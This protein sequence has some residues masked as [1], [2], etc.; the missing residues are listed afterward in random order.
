MLFSVSPLSIRNRGSLRKLLSVVFFLL[1]IFVPPFSFAQSQ[2]LSRHAEPQ[3]IYTG[4]LSAKAFVDTRDVFDAAMSPDGTKIVLVRSQWESEATRTWDTISIVNANDPNNP[5]ILIKRDDLMVN[6]VAWAR[7]DRLIASVVGVSYQRRSY[8]LFNQIISIDANTGVEKV[9]YSTPIRYFQTN[10]QPPH[11]V[12]YGKEDQ[13]EIFVSIQNGNSN[14]LTKI[15]IYTGAKQ[16]IENGN[17]DTVAWYVDKNHRAQIRLDI[18]NRTSIERF[19]TRAPHSNSWVQIATQLPSQRL[20]FEV[21]SLTEDLEKAYLLAQPNGD[22]RRAV[23]LYDLKTQSYERKI[24]ENDRY[25]LAGAFVSGKPRIFRGAYYFDHALRHHFS[26]SIEQAAADDIQAAL[27]EDKSWHIYDS[28]FDGEVWL[29]AVSGPRDAG[30]YWRYDFSTKNLTLIANMRDDLPSNRLSPMQPFNWKAIDGLELSGYLTVPAQKQTKMPLIVMPHGGPES[31]DVL[32]FDPWAQYFAARGF[33]V[34]QPNFRGS[35]GFGRNFREIGRRQ[36]GRKMRTDIED[37]VDAIIRRGEVD[38]SQIMMIGAS[39]GGYA[40]LN[41]LT[42]PNSRYACGIS[43]AGVSDLAS[44]LEF[45]K[46]RRITSSLPEIFSYWKSLIGDPTSE[47]EAIRH[48]SPL[49]NIGNLKVPLLLIHGRDDE[50]VPMNQSKSFYDAAFAQGKRQ[51]EIQIMDYVGH[52][53]WSADTHVTA[54]SSMSYFITKCQIAAETA[55][56]TR[57]SP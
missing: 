38:E 23:W 13:P 21:I 24:Y 1:F 4:P 54:L 42:Q 6:W 55:A 40:T 33:M 28:S 19:Y 50:I 27:G 48:N 53:G 31:R 12:S 8:T 16:V 18:E 37:G 49:Q 11:I 32:G 26:D 36:W 17:A 34:F 29:I 15:D 45:E 3:P 41:A 51:V 5:Q 47:A 30:S 35:D 20:E 57:V 9:L 10:Y 39:Y 52:S 2:T 14:N 56:R 22:E 46:T 7:P 43:I 44:M 25:D